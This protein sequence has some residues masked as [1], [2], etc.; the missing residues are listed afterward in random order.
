MNQ[1]F[2]LEKR[3]LE[4]S[5]RVIRLSENMVRTRAGTHVANQILR[6]G[7]SPFPNHGEAQAA[8]SNDDFIHKFKICL[9][10]LRETDR[11]LK[12]IQL[13]P[14]VSKLQSV[15]PLINETDELIRIFVKS[16]GTAQS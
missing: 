16:I 7:T 2:T 11:W 13:V 6:S 14:L 3:L 12:L 9:K 5:A 1:H 8:E 10:E 4:Y 15:Q